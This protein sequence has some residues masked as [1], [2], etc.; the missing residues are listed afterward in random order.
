MSESLLVGGSLEMGEGFVG[1]FLF[2]YCCKMELLVFL[3]SFFEFHIHWV[4]EG[5]N[6]DGKGRKGQKG[7]GLLGLD[8][9]M[10]KLKDGTDGRSVA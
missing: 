2:S 6:T 10:G 5:K 1:S 9:K 3:F 7:A 4:C 8:S